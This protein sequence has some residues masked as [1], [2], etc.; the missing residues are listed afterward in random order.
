MMSD[1]P[2]N[3]QPLRTQVKILLVD[4]EPFVRSAM[5]RNL[6]LILGL[7]Q[8]LAASEAESGNEAIQ[9]ITDGPKPDLIISDVGMPNGTGIDL[10]K[11]IEEELPELRD[12]ILFHSSFGADKVTN[13]FRSDQMEAGRLLEKPASLNALRNAVLR[14]LKGS[15]APAD[16]E[17]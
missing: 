16:E 13:S 5:K 17:E 9:L 11:F 1:T 6:R 14:I 3:Q 2:K 7:G 12:R 8:P 10:W 15:E 4:D